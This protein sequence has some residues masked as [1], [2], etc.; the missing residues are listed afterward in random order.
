MKIKVCG[1][2]DAASIHQTANLQPDFMG[3]VFNKASGQ[4][5]GD[6]AGLMAIIRPIR[7]VS[8]VG[9]FVNADYCEVITAIRQYG[10]DYVQ[11]NGDESPD[12]CA[13]LGGHIPLIKTFT[14]TASFNFT[15]LHDYAHY[16]T[17]FL[18]D[19]PPGQYGES[20]Q[21]PDQ[22]LSDQYKLHNPF[23]LSGHINPQ[24]VMNLNGLKHPSLLGIDINNDF[25]TA[26]NQLK[27]LI[28]EIRNPQ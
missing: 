25:K 7:T 14:I 5:V 8:K 11:L 24:N 3:F 10:L 4:Y 20:S 9:I 23:L 6:N 19:F 26:P 16:C 2:N 1:L 21:L 13:C 15:R 18:F 12:Y 17:Y 22:N 27:K 28:D